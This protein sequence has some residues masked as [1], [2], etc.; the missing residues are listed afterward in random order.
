VPVEGGKGEGGGGGEGGAKC[1]E[2]STWILRGAS[3]RKTAWGY[4]LDPSHDVVEVVTRFP[5][6]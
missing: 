1:C 5:F 3:S 4:M 2:S 6:K